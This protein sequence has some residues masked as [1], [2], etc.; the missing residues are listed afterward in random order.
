MPHLSAI[1]LSLKLREP[2]RKGLHVSYVS[3][4]DFAGMLR[5]VNWHSTQ[6]S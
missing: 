5:E 4:H 3:V 1:K 2:L 6:F